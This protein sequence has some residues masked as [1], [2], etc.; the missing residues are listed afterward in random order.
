MSDH[1]LCFGK[2]EAR[3]RMIH[4]TTSSKITSLMTPDGSF[5]SSGEII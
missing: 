2:R 3:L 4:M 1:K 5:P